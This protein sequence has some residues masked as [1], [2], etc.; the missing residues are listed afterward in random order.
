MVAV[1]GSDYKG[2]IGGVSR[3]GT[4]T[5]YSGTQREAIRRLGGRRRFR[6]AGSAGPGSLRSRGVRGESR[7]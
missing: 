3:Q 2:A 5:D 6:D 1:I 7:L 4:P